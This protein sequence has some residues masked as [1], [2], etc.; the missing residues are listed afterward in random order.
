MFYAWIFCLFVFASTVPVPGITETGR[1][2]WTPRK[3]SYRQRFFVKCHLCV[4][5]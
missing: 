5:N 2:H 1:G 4:R 3:L